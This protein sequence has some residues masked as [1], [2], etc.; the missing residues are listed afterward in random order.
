MSALEA[1][2]R[3]RCYAADPLGNVRASRRGF[4]ILKQDTLFP[5]G[6]CVTAGFSSRLQPR[7]VNMVGSSATVGPVG[8]PE[9]R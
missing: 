5:S 7:L 1:V 3:A 9:G 6:P 4:G 8:L 2:M